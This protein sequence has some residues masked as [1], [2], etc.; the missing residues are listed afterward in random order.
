MKKLFLILSLTLSLTTA[1]NANDK[2]FAVGDVFFCET[3]KHV[4]WV[5]AD[6]KQFKNYKLERFK[7]SIVDSKTIKF[8][9]DGSFKDYEMEIT[10]ML[11]RILEAKTD[12]SILV[13]NKNDF[14]YSSATGFGLGFKA[15][16]CDR[17]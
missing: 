7:F 16:T 11:A 10:D 3:L 15:A 4:G 8:G 14:N 2:P 9:K 6:E 12:Y 5:W 13:L 17:F 1:A